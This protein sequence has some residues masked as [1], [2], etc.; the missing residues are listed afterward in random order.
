MSP[1][2]CLFYRCPTNSSVA[3]VNPLLFPLCAK[4]CQLDAIKY[5]IETRDHLLTER[6]GK[7][8]IDVF[9]VYMNATY[10][11]LLSAAI[12]KGHL[13]VVQFLVNLD[14]DS[15]HK[16]TE[17]DHLPLTSAL[18]LGD[19]E[20][21]RFLVSRGVDPD[22]LGSDPWRARAGRRRAEPG[23]RKVRKTALSYA[24]TWLD[25]PFICS[26]I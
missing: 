22:F 3:S 2:Q 23:R 24:S 25:S 20:I 7:A 12:K 5:A 26:V 16:A 1:S 21:A 8:G 9:N 18:L 19:L 14:K 10:D 6:L 4:Q 11:E 15:V 13:G 17:F